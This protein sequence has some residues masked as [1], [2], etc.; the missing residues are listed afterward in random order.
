MNTSVNKKMQLE[1]ITIKLTI[2]MKKKCTVKEPVN[3]TEE[4]IRSDPAVQL[5]KASH[6]EVTNNQA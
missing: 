5:P 2:R 1:K 3:C 4:N 6:A